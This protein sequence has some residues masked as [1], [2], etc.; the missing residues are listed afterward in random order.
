MRRRQPEAEEIPPTGSPSTGERIGPVKMSKYRLL[1]FTPGIWL[2][3]LFLAAKRWI[4]VQVN[5]LTII[6]KNVF[7][8]FFCFIDSW[9]RSVL[10]VVHLFLSFFDPL[11]DFLC[12]YIQFLVSRWWFFFVF[13]P[14]HNLEIVIENELGHYSMNLSEFIVLILISNREVDFSLPFLRMNPPVTGHHFTRWM[15]SCAQSIDDLMD[16]HLCA[17]CQPFDCFPIWQ[18][19][20]KNQFVHLK[21][22]IAESEKIGETYLLF[23]NPD[24]PRH[25]DGQYS[26]ESGSHFYDISILK[27]GNR[28]SVF[29]AL[30]LSAPLSFFEALFR[31]LWRVTNAGPIRGAK[32]YREAADSHTS[33]YILYY[34]YYYYS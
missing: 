25:Q 6:K 9:S 14:N 5:L 26:I 8:L 34:Y 22:W 21:R 11:R 32:I 23:R 1:G 3:F 20:K 29:A 28:L 30:S 4:D 33:S 2:F 24:R 27:Y 19:P 31:H 12:V 7:F 10:P 16:R 15:Q 13:V 17:G 18:T